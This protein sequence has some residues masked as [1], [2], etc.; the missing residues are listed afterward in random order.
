MALRIR[1]FFLYDTLTRLQYASRWQHRTIAR[2]RKKKKKAHSSS[3]TKVLCECHL[4]YLITLV[5]CSLTSVMC[6]LFYMFPRHRDLIV[7]VAS[8]L[9]YVLSEEKKNET[10]CLFHF[11][12]GNTWKFNDLHGSWHT[13]VLFRSEM[14]VAFATELVCKQERCDVAVVVFI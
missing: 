8:C 14:S 12:Y 6:I 11:V 13:E 5:D 3:K 4:E 10:K 2:I 1:S 7:S 9:R